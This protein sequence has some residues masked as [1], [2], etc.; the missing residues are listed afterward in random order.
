MSSPRRAL[1]VFTRS[2][3]AEARAKDLDPESTSGIFAGFLAS[4][5]RAAER[6]GARLVISSPPACAK[7]LSVSPISE[8]AVVCA[9]IPAR[10]GE[11]LAAA[12]ENVFSLG[13]SPVAV[14]AGDTPAISDEELDRAFVA[15]EGDGAPLVLGPAGDGGVYL[16]GLRRPD[17]DLLAAVSLRDPKACEKLVLSAR[18]AGRGIS[19][20]ARREEVDSLADVRRLYRTSAESPVWNDY[21]LLLARALSNRSQP[22]P[23]PASWS[24]LPLFPVSPGRAPPAA[25]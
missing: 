13:F 6:A 16:I 4:W 11:R 19:L 12:V 21:R 10:F 7:R 22:L 5:K 25:A 15:L 1:V 17:S 24:V 2:P 8:G 23:D 9:Q 14:V 20:L 18:R 3:E